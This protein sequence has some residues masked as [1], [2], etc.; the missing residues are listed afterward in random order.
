MDLLQEALDL[1]RQRR[2]LPPPSRRRSLRQRAGLSQPIMAKAIGTTAAS[3]SRWESGER[4][5]RGRLL[6]AYSELLTKLAD[7]VAQR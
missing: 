2:S 5:P 7:E 3:V 1:A 4:T 6:R